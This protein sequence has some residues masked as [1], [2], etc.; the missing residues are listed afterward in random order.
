MGCVCCFFARRC[1]PCFDEPDKKAKFGVVLVVPE[2]QNA[3]SN[4]PVQSCTHLGGGKVKYVFDTTPIMSTY[5]LAVIVGEFDYVS[6]L[7]GNDIRTTVYTPR[8]K[9]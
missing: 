6:V 4:M 8:G 3:I 1:F 2:G 9:R 5:L 7:S